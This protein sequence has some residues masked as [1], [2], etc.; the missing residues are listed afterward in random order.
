MFQ[1]ELLESGALNNNHPLIIFLTLSI[2]P[3]TLALSP[4][5]SEETLLVFPMLLMLR[6]SI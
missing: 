3:W 1:G 6:G 4:E 5:I 2:P